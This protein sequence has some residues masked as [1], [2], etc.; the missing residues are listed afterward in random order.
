MGW[1]NR[2]ALLCFIGFVALQL[3]AGVAFAVISHSGPITVD[4]TWTN[5][6]SHLVTGDVTVS[7]GVTLTIEAGAVVQF[8]ALADDQSS[9][10]DSARVE[11]IID[12]GALIVSGSLSNPAILSSNAVAATAGD[13]YG[14][15]SVNGGSVNVQFATIEH[16]T[17]GINYQLDG[18]VAGSLNVE[19]STFNKT[20]EQAIYL[21]ATN[22]AQVAPSIQRNQFS[23]HKRAIHIE[24]RISGTVINSTILGNTISNT[25]L[26]GLYLYANRGKH[27]FVVHDNVVSASG[28]LPYRDHANVQI[29]Y[30]SAAASELSFKNNQLY[31]GK[32]NGLYLYDSYSDVSAE[33]VRNTIY[34]NGADGVYL[35]EQ[36]SIAN[37]GLHLTLSLNDI[38]TN[39]G[40]G[41]YQY[42]T[43]PIAIVHN[44][45]YTNSGDGVV[46]SSGTNQN[47]NFNN[48]YDNAGTYAIRNDRTGSVDARYNW[49]GTALTNEISTG[50]N[51]KNL[52][53]LFDVYDN[54]ARGVIDYA[55][56]LTAA[57]PL[58]TVPTSF[59]KS[60]EDGKTLKASQLNITGS[61]VASDLIDRVE[62]STD[63]GVSWSVATGK[64]SWNYLWTVPPGDGTYQIRSRV[65]TTAGT[66]ETPSAGRSVTIDTS[67][68]TTSGALS[69]DETWSGTVELTGDV[70]VPTGVTLTVEPGTMVRTAA[71]SDDQNAGAD[72]SRTELIIDGGTLQSVGTVGTPITLTSNATTPTAGDWYGIRSINNGVINLHHAIVEYAVFGVNYQL[73]GVLIGNFVVEDSIIRHITLEGLYVKTEGGVQLNPSI[74]RNQISQVRR[75]IEFSI[76]TN[77]T[78][79]NSVISGNTISNASGRAVYLYNNRA[80]H[81]LDFSN[82]TISASGHSSF[83]PVHIYNNFSLLSEQN[84]KENVLS[85]NR[86][87]GLYLYEFRSDIISNVIGNTISGG[88]SD[89][90]YVYE[91]HYNTRVVELTL[92]LNNIHNNRTGISVTSSTPVSIIQ[93]NIYLNTVDGIATSATVRPVIHNINFNNIYDNAG[94]YAIKNNGT[95]SVDA[96]YNWWGTALTNEISASANPKNLSGLFDVYDNT[97]RGVIDYAQW[98][99]AILPIAATPTSFI[100]SPEDG[101]TLKASQLNITGSAVASDLIDRVEVSTDDGVSWSVATGKS[102]WNYLWTVPPGDG[103]YQIRSRV[104][105][106]AGTVETPSAGRSVTI[107]TSLPTTSGALS[108]DETWS[109]TVELTGDVTVPTGVTLTVEPG[110]MVRTAALSDDQNA[111]ADASRTELI[112]DGGTLQSVGTVGTP[113]TLTSNATTPT[114]GDW[115]GIRSI[116]NGVINLHHAIVEYAVFGVNYQL[117]GVLIGN[118]VVE[119]S[120]IR[121]T[122]LEGLYVKTEGGVQLNPSIQRNQISQVRRGI[123]FSTGNLS[124]GIIN[125]TISGNTISNTAYNGV[126]LYSTQAKH[127]LSFTD[128][129]IYTTGSGTTTPQ[130]RTAVY[131]SNLYGY[132]NGSSVDLQNNTIYDSANYGL[133]IYDI[134]TDLALS[135]VGNTIRNSASRGIYLQ[136]HSVNDARGLKPVLSLNNIYATGGEGIYADINNTAHII[137]NNIYDTT[138]S[139]INI[140]SAKVQRINFNNIYNNANG[141]AVY[142]N[143]TG[144]VDA[145]Y[146]WFGAG[147]LAEIT[148]GTNPKNLSGL[149]DVYDNSTM[150]VIDYAQ[151]LTTVLPLRTIP[152]SWV[153]SPEDGKTLRAS[154]LMIDGSA[155]AADPIIR[156]EVSTDNGVTWLVANGTASWN[157]LWTVPAGDDTYQIRSR[158]ITATGIVEIPSAGHSVTIDTNLPTTSGALSGDE[159]WSDTITLTGDVTVPTGV[160][161]TIQPGTT[162]RFAALSDDQGSG[163]DVSRSALIVD[164]GVLNVSGTTAN[165]IVLTSSSS[166]PAGGD[167]Y[168]IYAINGGD[169]SVQHAVIEYATVSVDYRI[170]GALTQGSLLIEDSVLRETSLQGIYLKAENGAKLSPV[171]Q[172]NQLSEHQRGIHFDLLGIGTE[173][174]SS[175]VLNDVSNT[176]WNGIYINTSQAKHDL[177]LNKNTI[178]T[179]GVGTSSNVNR[180]AVYIYPTSSSEPDQLT[181][182]DNIIYNSASYG[183]YV[184]DINN[185]VTVNIN[186]N[187]IRDNASHGV[188][189]REAGGRSLDANVTLNNIYANGGEGVFAI[190][191]SPANI[192]HNN[193]Y[194]S[195][196]NGINIK[197]LKTQYI[198]F[199]NIYNNANG[200]VVYNNGSG[201]ID[202]RYNWFGDTLANEIS[203]G[204]NPKNISGLFDAYDDATKGGIDYA[205]GLSALLPLATTP[206]SWIKN[207]GDGKS[208]KASQLI[209]E[210][211][212]VAISPIDRV[213]VSTDNGLTWAAASGIATWNYLWS[214]PA[215]DGTYQIRSRVV[216]STGIVEVPS[217]GHSVTIDSSLPTSTG[218]LSE[219]ETWSGVVEITGD[220]TVPAG[221]SLTILPGTNINFVPKTDDRRAGDFTSLSELIIEGA[222]IA[223]GTEQQ[224]I[225][226][227]SN[228]TLKDKSDWGG[229]KVTGS[230]ILDNVFVEYGKFGIHCI[231]RAP[232]ANCEIRNSVIAHSSGN[233][234]YIDA[235]GNTQTHSAII[236]ANQVFDHDKNGIYAQSNGNATTL[237]LTANSNTVHNNGSYGFY[238]YAY[239]AANITS[240]TN[241]N[242]VYSNANHGMY[243]NDAFSATLNAEISGNKVYSNIG[244]TGVYLYSS[245]AY[246]KPTSYSVFANEIYGN[247][248]G[249][250]AY[251]LYSNATYT[252]SD[253]IIR[254]NVNDGIKTR[255]FTTSSTI[256]PIFSGNIIRS[257][258]TGITLN[259]TAAIALPTHQFI[260]NGIDVYN[261]STFDVDATGAWWGV[262]TTNQFN[263][264]TNPRNLNNISDNYDDP[265]KG[266]VDYANWIV[267]F[268]QPAI[269][270]LSAVS[271]PTGISQLILV[272]DKEANTGIVINGNTVVPIDAQTSWSYTVSLVEGLNGISLYAINPVGLHS[273]TVNVPIV[274][275][276][277]AP[278][279]FSSTPS[280]GAV[281]NVQPDQLEII[282]LETT[283]SIDGTASI[284]NAMVKN[285]LE[286]NVPGVWS[287]D[288]NRLLFTP[289]TTLE[290]GTYTIT[291]QPTDAPLGNTAIETIV[292]TIDVTAPSAVV[293]DAV[294]TPT[295]VSTV[296]LS[297]S[298]DGDTSI[299]VNGVLAVPLDANTTWAYEQVLVEGINQLAI[300]ARD[301]AGN[302]SP[303]VVADITLDSIAPQLTGITPVNNS[304][305]NQQPQG[306]DLGV[307]EAGTGI[308][309][310]NTLATATLVKTGGVPISGIW[311]FTVDSHLIFTP[312][313]ALAADTYVITAAISDNAG[314]VTNVSSTFTYDPFPPAL[315]TINPVT[316]PTNTK[317]QTLTGTKEAGTSIWVNSVEAVV[318][319]EAITWAYEVELV[320]GDN[321]VTVFSRDRAGNQS[322]NVT[323]AIRFDD[324]AP[325]PVNA[326]SVN[327][328]GDGKTAKLDWSAYDESVHGDIA[329]Y[330]VFSSQQ[331]FTNVSAM[332]ATADLPV[333]IKQYDIT[334]LNK[335]QTYFFAVVAIDSNSNVNN[336]VTPIAAVPADTIPPE[337]ISNLNVS[338][339]ADALTVTW[340]Q[341]LNAANDLANYKFYFNSDAGTLLAPTVGSRSLTGLTLATAYPIKV[342]SIDFDGNE[343][344]GVSTS[345]VTY[346]G[347]PSGL[348]VN[349]LSNSVELNWSASQPLEYVKQYAIYVSPTDFTNVMSMI[350]ALRVNA[351]KVTAKLAGL[352]NDVTYYFAV[353][354]INTSDGEQKAVTTVS[355]TPV[356]DTVGPDV[357]NINFNGVALTSGAT[358]TNAGTLTTNATD[359]GGISRVEY[360]VDGVRLAL[361]TSGTNN[362]S[363]KWNIIDATDGSHTLSAIVYDTLDNSTQV[364]IPVI[365]ALAAPNAP[366]ITSPRTGLSTNETVIAISGKAD[367]QTDVQLYNN[368]A[369]NGSLISVDSNGNYSGTI[370]LENGANSIT[371]TAQNRGGVGPASA[372]VTVTLDSSIPDAPVGLTA[373][374]KPSGE[375][376]LN[377][378]QSI[379]SN[380]VGYDIYRSTGPFTD[381]ATA[382]KANSSRISGSTYAD[383]PAEDGT[384]Y[385]SVV[386][387][388]TVGTASLPSNQTSGIADSIAPKAVAIEYVPSGNYDPV[389]TRTAPGQVAITLTVSEPLLTMPFLSIAPTNGIPTSVT[390]T[391]SSEL[392]YTGNFEITDTT[393]TGKAYAVFSARDVVGNRGSTVELGAT[394][395]IDSTG[396]EIS[397]II[398]SPG[399]P[400]KND[401]TAPITINFAIDLTEIAAGAGPQVSYQLS[402]AGRVKT[403]VDT[404]AQT[405]ALKWVGTIVLPSDAGLS[406]VENLT[407]LFSATDDLGNVSTKVQGDNLFQ[408]YQGDL[409]PLD[410]PRNLSAVAKPGGQ[411]ELSWEAVAGAAGYQLYRQAPGESELTAHQRVTDITYVDATTIDGTYSYGIASIRESN[412]QEGISAQSA[413]VSI[414]TDSQVPD[415]PQNLTL[416]LAGNGILAQWQEPVSSEPVTYN[417]YRSSVDIFDTSGLTAVRSNVSDVQALDPQPSETDHYYAVTAVDEAG[418]ESV[419]S[420]SAYLNF[421][422]LPV[423]N[424]TVEQLETA[425]PT[426]TWT[427]DGTTINS[428]DIYLE[429]AG[430]LKL[431][432]VTP[433]ID[434][435]YVDNGYTGDTRVYSIKAIDVNGIESIGHSVTLPQLSAVLK[436][437]TSIKRSIMNKV[438]YIVTNN[439]AVDVNNIQLK[440]RVDKYDH[441]SSNFNLAAG[442]T[443]TV[444]VIVGG[445]SDLPDISPL[446]TTIEVTQNISDVVRI[447]RTQDIL[448]TNAAMVL[449]IQSTELIRGANSQVKFTL[450]NTSD[451]EVEIVTALSS[452][453]KQSNEVRLKLLDIDNNVLSSQ[454]V[455]QDT[456]AGIIRLLN[457]TTVARIPAGGILT[458]DTFTLPVPLNAPD[459]VFVQLEIDKLHYHLGRADQV[460]INGLS[461]NQEVSL[462]NTPYSGS[463]DSVSPLN[464]YGGDDF[465]ISGQ[466]IDRDTGT[467]VANVPL[468]IVISNNG[469]ERNFDTLANASGNYSYTFKPLP[470]EAGNYTVSS[471]H[472]DLLERP[473]HGEFTISRV[474]LNFSSYN[475]NTA[476]DY[477]QEVKFVA[478][479]HEGTTATNLRFV[480]DAADQPEGTLPTGISFNL[481]NPITLQPNEES[482]FNLSF[483][484]DATAA[485]SGTVNIKLLSDESGVTPLAIVPITY[486][487][488]AAVPVIAYSPS[489]VELGVTQGS[490]VTE[491]VTLTNKGFVELQNV[492]L[493]LLDKNDAPVPEWIFLA[494][495]KQ[496]GNM[497]IGEK[498]EVSIT[499]QPP[500]TLV[501][502]IYEFKLR[503]TSSNGAEIDVNIYVSVSQSGMG[504]ALFK[505]SD[506]YTATLDSGGQVIQGLAGANIRLQ[507]ERVLSIDRTLGT[508]AAGEALFSDLPTGY[509]KYRATANNHQ[510]VIGRLQIKAGLTATEPV[511][512]NYNLVTVEWSVN[513][514][515]I[516]DRYEIVLQATFETNVPAAVV[517]LEPP[518]T[519]LPTMLP[520]DVFQG[521]L[522]LTNYGL[523][524]ADNLEI[525]LPQYDEYMKYE[526]LEG[527]PTSLAAK[528]RLV[529]PYRVIALKAIDPAL[530]VNGTG[531]GCGSYGNAALMSYDYVCTNGTIAGGSASHSWTHSY[532]SVSGCG[533]PSPGEGGRGGGYGVGGSGGYGGGGYESISGQECVGDPSCENCCQIPGTGSGK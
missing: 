450:E 184:Y 79:L 493:S 327:A 519:T 294:P 284:A 197:S 367:L 162:I 297:G 358:L 506:I 210:G 425:S 212:A 11:L 238:I 154:Q 274:L 43:H 225:S 175:I 248:I 220:V 227:T 526:F 486:T 51:P 305:L 253:N 441:V 402:A 45:I 156:V 38:Y 127:T 261:N 194:D 479:A 134:Y 460:S 123:E 295:K 447:Q 88:N 308:N 263:T 381:I 251:N 338:V 283:T 217:V 98:R 281:L 390:L 219:D 18:A 518:S 467:P 513:E 211:S 374:S 454:A 78:V 417:V 293:F 30:R 122:T 311:S 448:V 396:P 515:T 475:L 527:L 192:I 120:I 353:T 442:A 223:T 23:Q 135:I 170:N 48:I 108:G 316:S 44:N 180:A 47:I 166:T 264:G 502:G 243:F 275:D 484:G 522:V 471:I 159:T 188:Y 348:A 461:S 200:Y 290:P 268:A 462:V 121:H 355:A 340:S 28:T 142:N 492:T 74:Q 37:Q 46:V 7:L 186:N 97:A 269:P 26:N 315:P 110:T 183:L 239:N 505:L 468:R 92:E 33:V 266:V 500:A 202:A 496:Q 430:N 182:T 301:A 206:V 449:N 379:T 278:T 302:I 3:H 141:F 149:F 168:G 416:L 334:G 470:G 24:S 205:Q 352:T 84:I 41:I 337:D 215:G 321:V 100:K 280:N 77:T 255:Y 260:G 418:N 365:V 331:L 138:L 346:L 105:T 339:Q 187:V 62:V 90:I 247:A 319:D 17:V 256:S 285:A 326:L 16:A 244:K 126:Y 309:T 429:N 409:P 514:I 485:T 216:T 99:T 481:P 474:S 419:P 164:G 426:I 288:F 245:Y 382:T 57:L 140:I 404:L 171:V 236:T 89:G 398:I 151:W 469:F 487:L 218:S 330:K 130:Y 411:V 432:G 317:Q 357:A 408:V 277:Q 389:T 53:G 58:A 165:P 463:V 160:T 21:V 49:W 6:D 414:S 111:G 478:K 421:D 25:S 267:V 384:Y 116:N 198:N 488:T 145:R 436:E 292:F 391:Q 259:T 397:N 19:D 360:L 9:G 296:T 94:T 1:G 40:A 67:L 363:A 276:T 444:F 370:T 13:W 507:N 333:G 124:T 115:Y 476:I 512:L 222:M 328:N 424:I 533:I 101:K 440:V 388:N 35:Y 148:A 368:A 510:E 304:Y 303:T 375:V 335:G 517:V 362:Y 75:G 282:L 63:D 136:G 117:N 231:S 129:I 511:F 491:R 201:S 65:I 181:I 446:V 104:I 483:R 31:D 410:T 237:N 22:G 459:Q 39:A 2:R 52:S 343:S 36:S 146:N 173:V 106:T 214:V 133:H 344:T 128:N 73:N 252:I 258:G 54:T 477:D 312:T 395:E 465:I 524:R 271:T 178:H 228:A 27:D 174:N 415:S 289:T 530:V 91:V 399:E 167:W 118:F 482:P 443:E 376:R 494:V 498:R 291:V 516:E 163:I 431:N 169:V 102:S 451:T 246:D 531:G 56:W 72:A 525:V 199:N 435:N 433:L 428:Y 254:D 458:T 393:P 509:Y 119:D 20:T 521:E 386:A 489:F 83:G 68:P 32:S 403:A 224:P 107:D 179:T 499:A 59:I 242:I 150:G 229:I 185:I 29:D 10:V 61:A 422:L 480:F 4:Q 273:E 189:L 356:L 437:G 438:E 272:G 157:Y 504:N 306:I 345:G 520:G 155:V 144:A 153:K 324:T 93:N 405:D 235:A 286:A 70:T 240:T 232:P 523:I 42:T 112:I 439:S 147:L 383:V 472:P 143:G 325:L 195:I 369:P 230:A 95:N 249:L 314:N 125:S 14:I 137:N 113:I 394:L 207:P 152:T 497:A 300:V 176:Q 406:E 354:A 80:K 87:Y 8:T 501:D 226:I 193:I 132:Y 191:N 364:D 455:M 287:V 86:G 392:V 323:A 329:G 60:P 139:G 350:P 213:E 490:S 12:A 307:V 508:D 412:G 332:S 349:P 96:R 407:F 528:E 452:G 318:Y 434:Q 401:S 131:I 196:L 209:I 445:Y 71:L 400:I 387:I 336:S 342:T 34:N 347:N 377:W 15:R 76:N 427:H 66:V 351:S 310:A 529:I 161:L 361:S 204:A 234:I 158:V 279:V 241:S 299:Y 5:V 341:S 50:A 413:S 55:Q 453:T 270:V 190:I 371:T 503:A 177:L 81:D 203:S 464:S 109:G 298:K 103:T 233:G 466:A 457:K 366:T 221:I 82:N 257:N 265:T 172:R 359:E 420:N 380:V 262:E 495:P 64:S 423:S 208:L 313:T 320:P 69:G 378:N 114:A 373:L 473:V 322:G 532:G 385:Y 85:G 250:D 372:A 456:G